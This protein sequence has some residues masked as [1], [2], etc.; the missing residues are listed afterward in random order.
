METQSGVVAPSGVG[1]GQRAGNGA[2]ATDSERA[3]L[4]SSV[5]RVNRALLEGLKRGP[6]HR[7]G[8]WSR[9]LPIAQKSETMFQR[10][11]L[12]SPRRC[13]SSRLR[14]RLAWVN[15]DPTHDEGF[16]VAASFA[17]GATLRRRSLFLHVSGLD[18]PRPA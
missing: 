14:S 1:Q 15:E 13:A 6:G 8:F 18:S 17:V 5:G 4:P 2:H 11:Y 7:Q 3:A 12:A 9:D 16:F 10:L